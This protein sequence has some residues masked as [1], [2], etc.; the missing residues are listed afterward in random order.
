MICQD[1]NLAL[2]NLISL[3]SQPINQPLFHKTLKLHLFLGSVLEVKIK[4][5]KSRYF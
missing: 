4:N 5:K 3:L 2:P 1:L